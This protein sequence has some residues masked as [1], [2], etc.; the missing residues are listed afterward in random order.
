MSL[1]PCFRYLFSW[2]VAWSSRWVGG[3]IWHQLRFGGFAHGFIMHDLRYLS[4][5][6]VLTGLWGLPGNNLGL[7][8]IKVMGELSLVV[9]WTAFIIL[10]RRWTE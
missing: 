3:C 1:N 4:I 5:V 9:G 6:D 2:L 10:S 7:A 8:L